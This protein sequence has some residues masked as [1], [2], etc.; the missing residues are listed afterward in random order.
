MKWNVK[1]LH[2]Y[3]SSSLIPIQ[4]QIK[5]GEITNAVKNILIFE[6]HCKISLELTSITNGSIICFKKI[7]KIWGENLLFF[8]SHYFLNLEINEN[9]YGAYDVKN[10]SNL[11]FYNWK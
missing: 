8:L 11:Y 6:Y 10:D 9:E 3:P 5:I 1:C 7:L 2:H 4:K